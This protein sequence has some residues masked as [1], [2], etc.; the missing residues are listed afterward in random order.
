MNFHGSHP[1]DEADLEIL[2]RRNPPQPDSAN[3]DN[4]RAVSGISVLVLGP[5]TVAVRSTAREVVYLR[6]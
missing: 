5:N 3:A 2:G 4:P 6:R 1:T